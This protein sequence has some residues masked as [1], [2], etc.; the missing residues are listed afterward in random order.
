[1][2]PTT[3]KTPWKL[4]DSSSSDALTL[5]PETQDVELIW[6]VETDQV[7]NIKRKQPKEPDEW[8]EQL[9]AEESTTTA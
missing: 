9:T 1:L 4:C 7:W 3:E 5:V 8:A 2:D 6:I